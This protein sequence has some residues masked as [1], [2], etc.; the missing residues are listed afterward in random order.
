[1]VLESRKC[2]YKLFTSN[3][4]KYVCDSRTVLIRGRIPTLVQVCLLR[5]KRCIVSKSCFCLLN[6]N[7]ISYAT[8]KDERTNNIV[9]VFYNLTKTFIELLHVLWIWITLI[10]IYTKIWKGDQL[11][12]RSN[13][14]R[15]V[16]DG[17]QR[18]FNWEDKNLFL[19]LRFIKPL[20][21]IDYLS[22]D[23]L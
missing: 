12:V 21:I 10:E 8:M 11:S 13:I 19:L 23:N 2:Y 7:R 16:V 14:S 5:Q 15:N 22:I 1:M 18:T 4:I 3:L 17:C 6:F 9:L 20:F